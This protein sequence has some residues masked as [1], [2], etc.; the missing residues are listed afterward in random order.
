VKAL[1]A[2]NGGRSDIELD[3]LWNGEQSRTPAPFVKEEIG[4][5]QCDYLGTPQ[6]LT[7][8]EGRIA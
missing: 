1:T 6:E 5:Y 4:F 3:P 8:H 7:D 2:D